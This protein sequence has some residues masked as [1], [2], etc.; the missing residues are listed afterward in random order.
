MA[1]AD[2]SERDEAWTGGAAFDRLKDFQ[3]HSANDIYLR[4]IRAENGTM[5]TY[6]SAAKEPRR[7]N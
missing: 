3:E 5:G 6:T 2:N 7:V 4:R 1:K